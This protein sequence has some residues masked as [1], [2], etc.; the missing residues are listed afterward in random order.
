[1]RVRLIN[2]LLFTYLLT[3]LLTYLGGFA[4]EFSAGVQH[5]VGCAQEHVADI[6]QRPLAGCPLRRQTGR[7]LIVAAK[8]L[9]GV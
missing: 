1:V 9:T 5:G 6:H 3:Y 7:P 8:T 2:K 4:V